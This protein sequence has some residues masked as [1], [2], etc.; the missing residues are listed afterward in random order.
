MGLQLLLAAAA[1]GWLWEDGVATALA[2]AAAGRLWE[3]EVAAAIN[4]SSSRVALGG[5]GCS[6]F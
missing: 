2:A 3:D 5:W 1:A 4:S 6:S